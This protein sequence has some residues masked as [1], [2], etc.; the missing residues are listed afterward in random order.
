[1][2]VANTVISVLLMSAAYASPAFADYFHNHTLN[3]N[4]NIGSAP[5]PTAKDIRA[6]NSPQA[7]QRNQPPR[8][9]ASSSAPAPKS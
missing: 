8:N 2:K 5:N 6:S 9:V 4:L 1:M 7:T 3:V